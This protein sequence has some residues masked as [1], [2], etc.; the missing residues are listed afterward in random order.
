ME[1]DLSGAL[2]RGHEAVDRAEAGMF[3]L[4][5]V[6]GLR[7]A[8]DALGAIFGF[9]DEIP[10]ESVAGIDQLGKG[11]EPINLRG[12]G[13]FGLRRVG[14]KNREK[15]HAYLA[16]TVEKSVRPRYRCFCGNARPFSV[17]FGLKP[18]QK[19][20]HYPGNQGHNDVAVI[21]GDGC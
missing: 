18:Q 21:A 4:V 9:N 20:D 7:G 15:R 1:V 14:A 19:K 11:V 2:H 6:G 8:A 10:G 16:R 17:I 3:G 12:A 13:R 5:G